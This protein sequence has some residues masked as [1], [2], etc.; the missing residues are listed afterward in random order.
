M[1]VPKYN[2]ETSKIKMVVLTKKGFDNLT[3][4]SPVK[5]NKRS[6][7]FIMNGMLRRLQTNEI[8]QV[9]QV[10]QFYDQNGI[11]VHEIKK[12]K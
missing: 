4:Y 1:P 12:T 11:K 9:A 8:L 2:R 3:Q 5:Y 7:E 6:E 10:I